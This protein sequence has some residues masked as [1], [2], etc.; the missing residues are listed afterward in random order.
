MKLNPDDLVVMLPDTRGVTISPWG[1]GNMKLGPDVVS[2]SKLAIVSCPGA[3]S[4]CKENCYAKRIDGW[5]RLVHEVN[6]HEHG[7]LVAKLPKDAYLVRLHVSGDFDSVTYIQSWINLVRTN[8]KADFWGYTRSWNVP[9]LYPS[10]CTL[11]DLPNMQLFAS[12]DTTMPLPDTGWRLAWIEG[13]PRLKDNTGAVRCPEEFGSMPN[14]QAC[15]FCFSPRARDVV[16]K[17]H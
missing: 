5:V 11:R 7:E 6:T 9:E 15:G 1:K 12:V 3:S 2:Y 4:W 17:C 14:C 10:L 13:D 16:F 8:P